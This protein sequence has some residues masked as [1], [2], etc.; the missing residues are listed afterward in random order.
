[1]LKKSH[2]PGNKGQGGRTR[3]LMSPGFLFRRAT[4]GPS[5]EG[6]SRSAAGEYGR[7]PRGVVALLLP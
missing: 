4:R 1:M 2:N 5:F 6:D 7:S 3:R